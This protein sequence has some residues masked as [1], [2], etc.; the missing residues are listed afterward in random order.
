[1]ARGWNQLEV[2]SLTCQAID[3]AVGC[4]INWDISQNIYTRLK[5]FHVFC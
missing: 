2:S 5:L 4:D 1:M 3:A